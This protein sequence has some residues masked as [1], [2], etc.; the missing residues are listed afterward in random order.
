MLVVS[1]TP[2]S[3]PLNSANL[4]TEAVETQN[5][6]AERIPESESTFQSEKNRSA[7]GE[8]KL[9]DADR[10]VKNAE[11]R[12]KIFGSGT[13]E[14]AGQNQTTNQNP[15]QAANT[16]AETRQ[17]RKQDLADLATVRKLS[18]IDRNVKAHEQAHASVGG[19][20]TGAPSYTYQTGPNGV[21]YAVAGEVS[22]NASGV[23]GNPQA[24][25]TQATQV[26]RAALAP[27]NPSAT[28]RRVASSAQALAAK[29]R[30]EIAQ[31]AADRVKM[32]Q[33]ESRARI[34]GEEI[35]DTEPLQSTI[36]FSGGQL[37]AAL[38]SDATDQVGGQVS[39]S[40]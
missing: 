16:G 28:D 31:L 24:T 26:A 37:R 30:I 22:I 10:S 38:A 32:S 5:R 13:K 34:N 4:P 21:R 2:F 7:E 17:Q 33:N 9:S 15:Q 3:V 35:E 6:S 29:A 25:L 40:A 36:S 14:E 27:A 19:A 1:P 11:I 39:A 8:Q 20:L 12:E 23:S 18:A